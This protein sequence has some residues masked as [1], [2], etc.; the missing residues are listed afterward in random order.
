MH[1]PKGDQIIKHAKAIEAQLASGKRVA[2]I[3][4]EYG[5]SH[6]CLKMNLEPVIGT[7]RWRLIVHQG[8]FLSLKP[9]QDNP[10]KTS[11][12]EAQ[13]RL[14]SNKA[15]MFEDYYGCPHCG[16]E[17]NREH[18]CPKCMTGHVRLAKRLKV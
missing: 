12:D 6:A 1:K 14:E 3:V 4:K 2:Q 10:P 18:P 8:R 17:S 15:A 5:V 7:E 11:N 9:P 16:G 13:R